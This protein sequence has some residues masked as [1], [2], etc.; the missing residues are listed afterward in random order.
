MGWLHAV[1]DVP[2]AQERE[3]GAF[4]SRV[5]GW[6]LGEPWDEDP[7]FCSFRP[8]VG[9]AYVHLQRLGAGPARVHV[10]VEADDLDAEVDRLTSLGAQAGG[11][12]ASWWSLTSPGGLPFC[13]VPRSEQQPSAPVSWPDGHRARLVQVCVDCPEDTVAAEVT[14][15]RAAVPARWHP[16]GSA[17]FVGK[18]Y[19]QAGSP[20]Q[21]LFQRLGEPTGPVRAHLDLGTD[22]LAADAARIE[23]LGAPRRHDGRGWVT[24]EDPAGVTFCTTENDPGHS[25]T[26][27]L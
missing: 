8:P 24:L 5:L 19:D 20:L 18:L 1:I 16:S 14:F 2:A 26:R 22:D 6:P 11:R 23:A 27:A 17:E 3:V 9:N 25:P 7:A 12:F 21:L 10:D 15:W 4:W 13:V